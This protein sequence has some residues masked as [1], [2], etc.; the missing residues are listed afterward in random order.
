MIGKTNLFSLIYF[1]RSCLIGNSE[2]KTQQLSQ[3]IKSARKNNEFGVITSL[4]ISD[5]EW[6]M[7]VLEGERSAIQSAFNRISADTRHR[8]V[9][10]V[11]WREVQRREFFSSCEVAYRSPETESIFDRFNV[12]DALAAG[13]PKPGVIHGLA[14]ALQADHLARNGVNPAFM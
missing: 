7:Q 2:T 13:T 10:I 4:L 11:Q 6:F 1:S 9:L 3:L 12:S 5:R 14:L 8:S